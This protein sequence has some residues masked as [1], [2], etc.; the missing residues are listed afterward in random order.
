MKRFAF[1]ILGFF[2]WAQYVLA[3]PGASATFF[4]KRGEPFQF[5]F[6][7][8]VVN[9]GRSNV[10]HIN[11]IPAG[12]HTAEFRIPGRRGI[13]V[14]RTRVFLK[15]GL[16]S[17]FMVQVAGHG[18]QAVVR[19]VAEMPLLPIYPPSPLPPRPRYHEEEQP[20]YDFPRN[21]DRYEQ[22]G[23]YEEPRYPSKQEQCADIMEEHQVNRLLQNL[24]GKSNESSKESIARQALSQNTILAEDVKA[25]MEQF[26]YESTRLNFA[27]YAYQFTCDRGNFYVVNEALTYDASI[28]ELERYL[29]NL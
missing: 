11:D 3:F 9:P 18:R 10:I 19:K 6:D 20:G 25:I 7:G 1:L 12:Y 8:H 28:R 13:L 26:D 14:H 17:E 15:L 24:T 23:R 4:S 27:K 22:N 29:N 5:L 16:Q 21:R 2:F